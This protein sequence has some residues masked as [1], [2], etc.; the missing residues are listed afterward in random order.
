M[1]ISNYKLVALIVSAWGPS[2]YV[3]LF[4]FSFDVTGTF[5]TC[6]PDGLGIIVLGFPSFK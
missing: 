1:R 4:L 5:T 3:F 6:D 2:V